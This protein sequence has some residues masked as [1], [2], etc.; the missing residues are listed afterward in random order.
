M[1]GGFVT[2]VGVL[3]VLLAVHLVTALVPQWPLWLCVILGV[4]F[5]VAMLAAQVG[6]PPDRSG[7][8]D[9]EA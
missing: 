2:V 8:D 3:A 1:G 7:D 9:S 5:A 4:A 6:P